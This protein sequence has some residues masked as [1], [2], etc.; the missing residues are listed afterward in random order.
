[1][2]PPVPSPVPSSP[3]ILLPIPVLASHAEACPPLPHAGHMGPGIDRETGQCSSE[4]QSAGDKP[5]NTI[6]AQV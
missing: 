4:R 2:A 1:M 3:P 6:C 5:T